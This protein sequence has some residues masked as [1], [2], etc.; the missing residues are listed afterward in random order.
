MTHRFGHRLRRLELYV[1]L[2]PP[3][4]PRPVRILVPCADGTPDPGVRG[5]TRAEADGLNARG[6]PTIWIPDHDDRPEPGGDD[7][8]AA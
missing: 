2:P 4:G 7:D 3:A 5:M 6:V 8:E 1:P